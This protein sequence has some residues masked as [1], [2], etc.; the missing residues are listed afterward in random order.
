M[1]RGESSVSARVECC[2]RHP[3]GET[4]S[5]LPGVPGLQCNQASQPAGGTVPVASRHGP[6]VAGWLRERSPGGQIVLVTIVY[7]MMC[8]GGYDSW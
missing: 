7:K 1:H 6:G 3:A 8:M 5:S 2:F 4:R